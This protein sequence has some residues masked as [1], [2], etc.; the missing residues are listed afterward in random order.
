M[1][2]TVVELRHVFFCQFHLETSSSPALR[3]NGHLKL[4]VCPC[5]MVHKC[6]LEVSSTSFGDV[7]AQSCMQAMRQRLGTAKRVM[8]VGNG[9]IALELV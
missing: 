8:V 9:G 1:P 6:L 5:S 2:A 3:F 7:G 4:D